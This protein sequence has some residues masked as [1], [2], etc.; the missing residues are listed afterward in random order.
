MAKTKFLEEEGLVKGT[1]IVRRHAGA[2]TAPD[3]AR[4]CM[5]EGLASRP[6]H[7]ASPELS[8]KPAPGSPPWAR[9]PRL[10]RTAGRPWRRAPRL[11]RGHAAPC[12]GCRMSQ[13]DCQ[14]PGRAR[15]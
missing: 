14:S 4:N 8:T 1:Q 12:E 9:N 13:R 11:A 2:A 3:S 7:A 10:P 15:L 5:A 6:R